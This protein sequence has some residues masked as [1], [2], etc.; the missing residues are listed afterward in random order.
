M[1]KELIV[2]I[3]ENETRVALLENSNLVELYIERGDDE[4]ITGNIYKGTI[5]RVL[6]GMQAAFVDIG[7]KQAAFLYIDDVIQ[8]QNI[9][10]NGH[11]Q[12]N[13][14][15]DDDTKNN[16]DSEFVYE[17]RKRNIPIED[18]LT[19]GQQIM[20]QV[21]KSPIGT[22]GARV[23]TY[24]SIPGRYLVLMPSVDHIGISKRIEN[25]DERSRLRNLISDNR[26]V[27]YGY[28]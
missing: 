25:E 19:E 20:V 26:D 4:I 10:K 9:D 6:P 27:N 3:T 21:V 7:I 5:Q 12:K 13:F 11:P 28:I 2:N 23:S 15:S 24:I 1:Y 8:K 22:K 14:N 16:E 17:T 18:I